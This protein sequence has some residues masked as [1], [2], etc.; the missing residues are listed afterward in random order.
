M[1][2]DRSFEYLRPRGIIMRHSFIILFFFVFPHPV[3]AQLVTGALECRAVDSTGAPIGGVNVLVTGPALQGSRGG[4]T[5]PNGYLHLF[6]LPAGLY[7]AQ[8]RHV[9]F[10][11]VTYRNI[12]V[13]LG[14]T[15]NLGEIHLVAEQH[16]LPEVIVSE[17]K[18]LVDPASTEMGGDL[19]AKQFE[20]LPIDRDYRSI[21]TL[22]PQANQSF[23]GDPFNVAGSTGLENKYFIDGVDVTDPDLGAS[24]TA[25]PYNFIDEVQLREGGYEAEYRSALGGILN[26]VT[27]AGGN[28]FRAE[29]FGFYTSDNFTSK[30]KLSALVPGQG[31]SVTYDVGVGVGGPILPDRLWFFGSYNPTFVHIDATVPGYGTIP[32]TR[33]T[34]AFAAK[35]SWKPSSEI[36]LSLTVNGDPLIRNVVSGNA[37]AVENPDPY[38]STL[39]RGGVN[40]SLHGTYLS[41]DNFVLDATLSRTTRNDLREPSTAR[42]GEVLFVDDATGVWS[43]GFGHRTRDD[44]VSSGID[45]NATK[46]LGVHTVKAGAAYRVL[47]LSV[48]EYSQFIARINDSRYNL[49]TSYS[50]GS[51]QNRIPSLFLQDAWRISSRIR[52]NIGL[53]WDGQFLVG[54]DGKVDQK[55]TGEWQP[56]LGMTFLLD[57][58]GD[59]KISASFG[60]FYQDMG[61]AAPSL[62]LFSSGGYFNVRYD[63]DPRIDPTGG[64]KGKVNQSAFIQPEVPDLRGQNFDEFSLGYEQ[65]VHGAIHVGVRG[66]YRVL[67]DAIEDCFVADS[68]SN[69]LGN[70]GRGLLS[71]F[72]KAR[73]EYTAMTLSVESSGS[74]PFNFLGSYV[75]SR[76]YG[77]YPG[78]FDSDFHTFSPNLDPTFEILENLRNAT[79]RLPNDRTHVFK[80]ACSYRFDF[81]LTVGNSFVWESGTPLNEF[82]GTPSDYP[83]LLRP[84]G[85]AGS[86]PAIWDVN[87]RLTYDLAAGLLRP[88]LIL[89]IFHIGNPRKVVDVDQFHY[90]HVDEN[91]NQIDPNPTYGVPSAFQPP[92]AFRLGIEIS[93]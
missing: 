80:F 76:S 90:Y 29:A 87:M 52:A 33:T 61:L 54:S 86:T 89:D 4:I 49:F 15:T 19:T 69:Y 82:G 34:H 21:A 31:T 41:S 83:G 93:Y 3:M 71:Q 14:G 17:T 64:T 27:R 92:M 62:Y 13:R 9:S 40:T 2:G 30:P 48:D 59:E 32:D 22:L 38:L 68:G 57:R 37:V 74:G 50:L 78:L 42:G 28:Q 26:V 24:G 84:R 8:L 81:G 18:L 25:L 66:I 43:G 10:R 1:T 39:H 73:R 45:V 11:R 58:E 60:R 36:M 79:G 55:I 88:R 70:P 35:L 5:D 56:R 63:H 51:V 47:S 72:P 91:G 23:F 6:D 44:R 75:L 67:R 65:V 7:S 77:N 85:T 12:P 46:I 20:P 16:E 53:R